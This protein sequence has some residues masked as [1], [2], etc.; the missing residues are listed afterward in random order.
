LH[1][2]FL[3]ATN[4]CLRQFSVVRLVPLLPP[5]KKGLTKPWCSDLMCCLVDFL[6]LLLSE[7][8]PASIS[9]EHLLT[10]SQNTVAFSPQTNASASL[11]S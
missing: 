11:A 9:F 6:F 4:S 7:T 2:Y 5:L 1:V 10:C 3:F 8:F